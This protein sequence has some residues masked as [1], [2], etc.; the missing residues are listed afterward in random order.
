MI[1]PIT[2]KNN[3]NKSYNNACNNT[4]NLKILPRN[5]N[6]ITTHLIIA[7]NYRKNTVYERKIAVILAYKNNF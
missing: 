1:R 2:C 6:L 3:N 4:S 7:F 5:N